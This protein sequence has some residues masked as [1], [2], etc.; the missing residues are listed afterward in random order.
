MQRTGETDVTPG[1]DRHDLLFPDAN[2]QF[3]LG[4]G[5]AAGESRQENDR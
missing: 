3:L 5:P 2:R 1:R 4:E